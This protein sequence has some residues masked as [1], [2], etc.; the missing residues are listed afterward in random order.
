MLNELN[1]ASRR[2]SFRCAHLFALCASVG[3]AAAPASA[4]HR[5]DF[6]VGPG[7]GIGGGDFAVKYFLARA[8]ALELYGGGVPYRTNDGIAFNVHPFRMSEDY[9]LVTGVSKVD[10]WGLAGGVKYYFQK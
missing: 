9:H 2:Q 1:S 5:G 7:F 10:S 6:V 8:I 3:F 4:Q